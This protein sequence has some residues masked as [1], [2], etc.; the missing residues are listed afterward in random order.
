M[1]LGALVPQPEG[2]VAVSMQHAYGASRPAHMGL[3]GDR[4]VVAGQVEGRLPRMSRSPNGQIWV[5]VVINGSI[6]PTAG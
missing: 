1:R 6:R 3:Y 5:R 4:R 2:D